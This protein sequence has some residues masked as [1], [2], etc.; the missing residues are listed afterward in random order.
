MWATAIPDRS[1]KG[2]TT[3]QLDSDTANETAT[4]IE[5]RVEPARNTDR[6]AAVA[7]VAVAVVHSLIGVG[8]TTAETFQ[9]SSTHR[10]LVQCGID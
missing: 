9:T 3:L 6:P 5:V 10:R 4:V 1:V 7:V 2:S 8:I